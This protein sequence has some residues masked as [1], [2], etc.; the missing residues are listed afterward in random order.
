MIDD[1]HADRRALGARPAGVPTNIMDAEQSD[2]DLWTG[3]LA[4]EHSF[5]GR[6]YRHVRKR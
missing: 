4:K 5:D 1:A 2:V 3:S 6:V